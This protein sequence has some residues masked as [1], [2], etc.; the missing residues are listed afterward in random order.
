MLDCF[1]LQGLHNNYFVRN[2]IQWNSIHTYSSLKQ[3][4]TSQHFWRKSHLW[5]QWISPWDDRYNLISCKVFVQPFLV[6]TH[7]LRV[8]IQVFHLS[9]H[10]DGQ[11]NRF[12]E[13]RRDQ[14]HQQPDLETRTILKTGIHT[15]NRKL[16]DEECRHLQWF[17]K[18]EIKLQ[19][20]TKPQLFLFVH[21]K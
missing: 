20:L 8:T 3:V 5:C 10:D 16:F 4:G 9:G 15:D 19:L 11:T 17:V 7:S 14:P 6:S 21:C 2:G 12:S 18:C 1:T 13:T